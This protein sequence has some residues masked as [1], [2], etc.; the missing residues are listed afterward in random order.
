MLS[1]DIID[2]FKRA[3]I[4]RNYKA[5]EPVFLENEPSTGMYLILNGEV[6]VLRRVGNGDQIRVATVGAGQTMG[7]ISLLLAQP[8]S[9]T[10][11]AMSEVECSLLT[12]TRLNDLRREEPDLSLQ[13]FEILAYTLAGH[14][15]DLNR[16]LDEARQEIQELK[17]NQNAGKSDFS[18]F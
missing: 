15:G 18:Y 17:A 3:G 1:A 7:E 14:I 12:Q 16:Q 6:E 4:P 2:G 5:G 13:L 10:V 11:V 8:H 9:A